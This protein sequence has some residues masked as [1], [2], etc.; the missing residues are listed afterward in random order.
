LTTSTSPSSSATV[1]VA[2][3]VKAAKII[4][5]NAS[6]GSFDTPAGGGTT[7]TT[8]VGHPASRLFNPDNTLLAT[9]GSSSWPAW[10]TSV[11]IGISGANNTAAQNGDCARFAATG[12]D[13]ATN[14]RWDNTGGAANAVCGSSANLYRV[15]EFDCLNGTAASTG[16]G[17]A[18]DGVFIRV[19]FDRTQTSLG[20]SENVMAVL[21]YAAS[22]L[23]TAAP[24]GPANCF[25]GGVFTPTNAGC[26]D[27]VWQMFLKPTASSA[28]AP[29][30]MMIPP[31]GAT[32][33]LTRNLGGGGVTTRQ[34]I[35]PMAAN[36]TTTIMQISR[37]GSSLDPTTGTTFQ[38]VCDSDG[39]IPSNSPFCV[40]VVFY[41]MT[42]YRI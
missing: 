5:T 41:S 4:F 3:G 36:P 7:N 9:A 42:L 26:A 1:A 34:F 31:L 21:E 16:T 2:G 37:I 13:T 28:P 25:V 14:C 18:T 10:I 38:K 23:N 8:G 15:S 17:A 6:S 27:M 29:Y 32:V 30:M 19:T 33:D 39:T 40:G 22:G 24:G 20:T 11:E 12:E 35:L